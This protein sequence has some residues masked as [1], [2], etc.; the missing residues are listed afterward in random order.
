MV[1]QV[2]AM[3]VIGQPERPPPP[4]VGYNHVDGLADISKEAF[5][6]SDVNG[7]IDIEQAGA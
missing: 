3:I 4:Y 1:R 2:C 5:V 7:E 6:V